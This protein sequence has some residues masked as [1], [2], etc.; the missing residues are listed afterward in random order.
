MARVFRVPGFGVPS[1]QTRGFNHHSGKRAD[2]GGRYFRSSWE[3]NIARMLNFWVNIGI[4]SRWE[5]E[6]CEFRF[7]ADAAA[8]A[9]LWWKAKGKKRALKGIERGAA[10]FYRP[11]FCI[12]WLDGTSEFWEVKAYLDATSKSKLSRMGTYYPQEKVTLVDRKAYREFERQY[13]RVIPE[14]E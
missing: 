14:W 10:S 7:T 13:C 6:P 5:Y 8:A 2:L 12:H 3:S 11:D 9:N 4:I 1:K